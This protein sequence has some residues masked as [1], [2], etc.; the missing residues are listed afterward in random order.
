LETIK[1]KDFLQ[2]VITMRDFQKLRAKGQCTQET[3]SRKEAKVDSIIN[4][5]T[6]NKPKDERSLF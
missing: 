5:I 1:V 3:C 2:A 6:E 4:K